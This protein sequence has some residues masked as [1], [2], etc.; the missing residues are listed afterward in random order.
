VLRRQVIFLRQI[1]LLKFSNILSLWMEFSFNSKISF[2]KDRKFSTDF[3][4]TK[5]KK[6]SV[7][8]L[9]RKAREYHC[10]YWLLNVV[11]F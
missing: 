2:C 3:R 8:V 11:V 4:N 1:S 10:G 9:K 5:F 6:I 7:W